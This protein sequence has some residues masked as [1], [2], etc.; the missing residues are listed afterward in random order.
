M[1]DGIEIGA[2]DYLTKPVDRSLLIAKIKSMLRLKELN[3][4]LLEAEELKTI[5]ATAVT[6]NHEINNPLT[7][8]ILNVEHLQDDKTLSEKEKQKTY[9]TIHQQ[10]IKISEVV[11]RLS[12]IVEPKKKK[13][14]GPLD[15]IDL[16]KSKYR[17]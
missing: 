6:A 5:A 17:E 10:A 16:D 12:E 11:K 7:G 8:I 14:A 13:H 3:E 2:D 15:M 9:N 1:V 4:K